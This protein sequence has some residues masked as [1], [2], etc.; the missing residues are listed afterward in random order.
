MRCLLLA[1]ALGVLALQQ[2][3]ELP[4]AALAPWAL[5]PLLIALS[6]ALGARRLRGRTREIARGAAMVASIAAVALGGFFYA[7]WRAELRLAD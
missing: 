4:P 3:R 2:Q 1:F 5:V 6:A 7:A